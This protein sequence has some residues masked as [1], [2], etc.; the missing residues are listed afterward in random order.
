MKR[1]LLFLATNLA[2]L[3]VLSIV[4]Q[5]LGID[6]YL[7]LR[8]GN[9]QGLLMF[10]ACSARRRTVDT[11]QISVEVRGCSMTCTPI[12]RLAIHFEIASEMNAPP[13]P[14]TAANISR[15]CRF[16]PRSAR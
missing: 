14:N 2:I 6:R 8:G 13:K 12:A 16:P 4:C 5:I 15:P 1:V 9:L 3:V 11:S 7:A 10:A